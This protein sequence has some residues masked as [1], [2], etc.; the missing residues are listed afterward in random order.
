M[1]SAGDTPSPVRVAIVDDHDVVH[2][3]IEAWCAKADPPIS[4]VGCS[5]SPGQYFERSR[6]YRTGDVGCRALRPAA[7]RQPPGLG[8]AGQDVSGGHARHRVLPHVQ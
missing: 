1:T 6:R 2:A 8:D 5:T 7:R 4:V 3:G